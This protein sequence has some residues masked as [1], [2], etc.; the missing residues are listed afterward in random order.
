MGA[1][2]S[3]ET[4]NVTVRGVQTTVR[5]NHGE[6]RVYNLVNGAWTQMGDDICGN[7]QSF[8]GNAVAL[9]ASGTTLAIGA[10]DDYEGTDATNAKGSVTIYEWNG[11]SW[12][13]VGDKIF[14]ENVSD[15]NG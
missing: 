7:L 3:F 15:E 5:L 9:S 12:S 2:K 8:T 1:V 6:V 4:A 11:T 10:L 13:Q 14:G